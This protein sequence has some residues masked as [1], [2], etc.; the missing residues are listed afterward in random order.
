MELMELN[1]TVSIEYFSS[2]AIIETS[3]TYL[4]KAL[5]VEPNNTHILTNKGLVPNAL[6]RNVEALEYFDK[7]ISTDP[8]NSY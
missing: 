6:G 1:F 7:D 4:D 8:N 5:K 2:Y 3:L